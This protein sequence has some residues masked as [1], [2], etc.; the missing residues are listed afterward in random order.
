MSRKEDTVPESGESEL[1]RTI[2][3]KHRPEDPWHEPRDYMVGFGLALENALNDAKEKLF[4]GEGETTFPVTIRFEA[5]VTVR[6][7]GAI[8]EYRAFVTEP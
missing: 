8:D 2:I 7:P 4:A 5:T 1:R 3:G 6:N